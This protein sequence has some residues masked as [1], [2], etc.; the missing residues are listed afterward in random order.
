VHAR[1][2]PWWSDVVQDALVLLQEGKLE[3]ITCTSF[4]SQWNDV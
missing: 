1:F 4:P 3:K 2:P